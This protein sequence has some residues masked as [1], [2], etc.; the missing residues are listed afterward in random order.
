MY[1]GMKLLD[2]KANFSADFGFVFRS[3]A[4][5]AV[6][7][8]AKLTISVFDYWRIKN[9]LTVSIVASCRDLAGNLLGRVPL[10]FNGA[11]INFTPPIDAGSVEIE[12]FS[13]V[14][15]RIPYAAVMGIYETPV[16]V[17]M[18]HSYARNHSASEI[19]DGR[20]ILE[21]REACIGV[22]ADPRV[23]TAAVFHNGS[24]ALPA[25]VGTVIITNKSG[26]DRTWQFDIPSMAPYETVEFDFATIAP[27]VLEHL[28][29]CDGWAALHFAN[30]SS[31]PR[32]LVRWRHRETGELQITHS[33]FDYTEYATNTLESDEVGYMSAPSFTSDIAQSDI[34]IY[35]HCTRG[36]YS[37]DTT[38]GVSQTSGG[39][40]IPFDPAHGERLTVERE[41][42]PLPA[43]LVTALRGQAD[44]RA[45]PFECSIGIFHGERPPK[46]F[47]WGVVSGRMPTSL[48]IQKFPEL[49]GTPEG[50]EI[51]F[52]LYQAMAD[53]ALQSKMS[54]ATLDDIPS[55][56]PLET[57]FPN[58][59]SLLGDEPGYVTMF[60]QWGGLFLLTAIRHGRSMTIEHSF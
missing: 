39:L 9:D 30:R 22:K 17:S 16:S 38:E 54:F 18:V 32:M 56:L 60:S 7:P 45:L 25:Q 5:F 51:S 26:V 36:I 58:A 11:V 20:A 13:N 59:S 52:A 8:E 19:E 46:R 37:V 53:R 31:F 29:G 23:E 10:D 28:V 24:V 48:L 41:D 14:N 6:F 15:L 50:V 55:E 44:M 57:L 12:A 3:S 34:V 2:Q 47:H 35:P 27:G 49:Y 42:G 40:V 4:I 1:S 33:N 43:R 21:V